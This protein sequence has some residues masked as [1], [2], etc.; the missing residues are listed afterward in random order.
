VR[1]RGDLIE[2]GATG[3]LVAFA[4]GMAAGALLTND[5]GLGVLA[6]IAGQGVAIPFSIHRANQR[7][8]DY[9]SSA[10]TG[11]L[12]G[13][14]GVGLTLLTRSSVGLIVVPLVQIPISIAIETHNGRR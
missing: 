8:R 4:A 9:A 14:A 5:I 6:A 7:E 13:A 1:I 10:L 3:A 11:V 12:T 2:A